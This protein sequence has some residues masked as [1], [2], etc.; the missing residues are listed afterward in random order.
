MPTLEERIKLIVQ[1]INEILRKDDGFL[2]FVTYEE[3]TKTA[4]F[5]LLGIFEHDPMAMNTFRGGIEKI[6]LSKIK[7][8]RRIE[9]IN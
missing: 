8:V 3:D 6:I 5:K 7:E 2:E 9:K 4:V 1:E